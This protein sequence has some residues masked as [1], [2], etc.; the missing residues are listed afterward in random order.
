MLKV[1]G[2]KAELFNAHRNNISD[3]D[4][5]KQAALEVHIEMLTFFTDLVN[6]LR[7][8]F[9]GEHFRDGLRPRLANLFPNEKPMMKVYGVQ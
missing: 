3:T 5:M 7:G 6:H 2:H 1:F 4:P 9:F 8:G